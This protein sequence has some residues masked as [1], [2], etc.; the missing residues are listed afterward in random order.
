MFKNIL[1]LIIFV[2][3]AF[4]LTICH[5]STDQVAKSHIQVVEKNDSFNGTPINKI[6]VTEVVAKVNNFK[7]VPILEKSD[8]ISAESSFFM[9]LLSLLGFIALSNRRNV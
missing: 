4:S 6:V 1:V 7:D 9:L 3:S 5:A 8:D 2:S